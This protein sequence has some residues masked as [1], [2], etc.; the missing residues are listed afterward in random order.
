MILLTGG[1][2]RTG[3]RPLAVS[4]LAAKNLEGE[5]DPVFKPLPGGRGLT[6]NATVASVPKRRPMAFRG[7]I[8]LGAESIDPPPASLLRV[9]CSRAFCDFLTRIKILRRGKD[10]RIVSRSIA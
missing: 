4:R 3:A 10:V 8:C 2:S 9:L 5:D 1:G 6:F 7:Q